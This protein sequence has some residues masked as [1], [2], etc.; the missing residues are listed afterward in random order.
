[1]YF[2]MRRRCLTL[3][4]L[5]VTIA[6]QAAAG[7]SQVRR[8]ERLAERGETA[9]SLMV[10]NRYIE[11]FPAHGAGHA[12][13]VA[14]V[15]ALS[16]NA[17][18]YRSLGNTQQSLT[19]LRRA[20]A[21][22]KALGDTHR[23]AALYNS[24]FAIYYDRHEYNQASDL[25][26]TALQ[27][28]LA[29]RDSASIR[30][31][32]N[33]FGLLYYERG[34]YATALAYMARAL[35]YSPPDDRMGRSLIHTNRAE[36][37][38]KQ[39]LY[40][41]AERELRRA[42]ALQR[43]LPF[44]ER[45][46]Q[47]RLNMAL[48]QARRGRGHE[49]AAQQAALYGIIPRLPLPMQSNSYQQMADIHFT[50]GDSLAALRDILAYQ[51]VDDSLRRASNDSQL[52]QL[53]VAYDA[54][55]LRQHN[56]NLQQT[57]DLFRLKVDNR[58]TMVYVV[59][60]FLVVLAVLLLILLRRMRA[61]KA[62]N[63]LIAAQQRQ[64][65]QYE[66]QEHRRRQQ[67]LTLEIDHKNRQLTSYTLDLAAVNAFHQHV[68]DTL[69][70]LRDALRRMPDGKDTSAGA[71]EQLRE[72]IL[73]LQHFNDKPLGDDFRVYFDEVHPGFLSRLSRRYV[74]SKQDLRLCAYL[75]LGMTT[76]EIAA[77]T[78]KE[79]RSVESSRNRLRKKLS[80][81]P[82]TN[83]QQFFAQFAQSED[84]SDPDIQPAS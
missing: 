79:V 35:S 28:S 40:A 24:I 2:A 50:L 78:F 46:V 51:R 81:P 39:S 10:L 60:S 74:L 62:K 47:T 69:S 19:L 5:L 13:S 16:V 43:G 37:Y 59:A 61:D 73:G 58:T 76:K 31:Y 41:P 42:L 45:M 27:M 57:V 68:S 63:A 23:L 20:I 49:A 26:Q 30:N 6:L 18:N 70:S 82:E 4:L 77:L 55:R 36:V 38:N 44:D 83:L 29:D 14:L 34:D 71:D 64:L 7:P 75:H 84:D 9:Q 12:D 56:T 25:L 32:C 65:L 72:L 15:S 80:L 52:Q 17:A 54:D 8:G 3:V 48:L 1:M 11:T 67:E 66:Q 33:N 53:L 21:V 22:A